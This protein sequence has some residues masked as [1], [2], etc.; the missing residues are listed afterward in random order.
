MSSRHREHK[1]YEHTS[2]GLRDALFDEL[3]DLRNGITTPHY[4]TA[5]S[6]IATN[7]LHS[8]ELDLRQAAI[9]E[10]R[11]RTRLL[12][13]SSPQQLLTDQSDVSDEYESED[14]AGH[15]SDL[16]EGCELDAE[17]S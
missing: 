2:A 15:V 9:E 11:E 8:V 13:L 4:A 3:A 10:A 6:K 14:E 16:S 5:V 7:I 17:V 1:A 12:A